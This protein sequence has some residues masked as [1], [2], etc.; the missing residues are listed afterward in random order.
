MLCVC[1]AGGQSPD[2][3][4]FNAGYGTSSLYK[5]VNGGVDWD[6]IWPPPNDLMLAKQTTGFVGQLEVDPDNSQ[7]LLQSFHDNCGNYA[8]GIGCFGS[9]TDGGVTWNV[10]YGTPSFE[11][12]VH[13]Y[14]LDNGHTWIVAS[15][16]KLLRSADSGASWTTVLDPPR[17]PPA[18]GCSADTTVYASGVNLMTSPLSDG[19]QWTKHPSFGALQKGAGLGYDPDHHLLYAANLFD[20]VFRMT[21]P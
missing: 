8:D 7:N 11:P 19:V 17:L 3:I 12:Q 9:T 18:N 6:V 1:A 21:A 4:Y 20:G 13:A 2:T 14:F 10:L 5:S 16:H 15:K